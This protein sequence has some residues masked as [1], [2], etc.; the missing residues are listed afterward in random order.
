MRYNSLAIHQCLASLQGNLFHK[1]ETNVFRE[2]LVINE[3]SVVSRLAM[4]RSALELIESVLPIS[5]LKSS[6]SIITNL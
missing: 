3:I 5:R 1:R 6:R 4:S 2:I